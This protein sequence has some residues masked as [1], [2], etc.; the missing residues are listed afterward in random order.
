MPLGRDDA[1]A[2]VAGE[3]GDDLV[4][5]VAHLHR[6]RLARIPRAGTRVRQPRVTGLRRGPL[7]AHELVHLRHAG[8]EV[9]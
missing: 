9:G 1:D 5:P 3:V 7:D 8:A 4:G 2:A 6:E